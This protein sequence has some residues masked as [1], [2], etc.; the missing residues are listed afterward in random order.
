MLEREKPDG[1]ELVQATNGWLMVWTQQ[2]SFATTVSWQ[3]E[4]MSMIFL[5]KLLLA[6][7]VGLVMMALL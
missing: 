2:L 3:I 1:R 4:S 6:V 7:G 5:F